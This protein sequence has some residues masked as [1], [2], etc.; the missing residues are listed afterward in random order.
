MEPSG[1][2]RSHWIG[3]PA[4][5]RRAPLDETTTPRNERQNGTTND[6]NGSTDDLNAMALTR[7]HRKL[8]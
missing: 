3:E 2:P 4:A 5:S 1:P 6:R 8:T 7:L